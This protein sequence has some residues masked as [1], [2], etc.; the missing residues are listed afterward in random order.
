M[1]MPRKMS[2]QVRP[3]VVG[4]KR[5]EEALRDHTFAIRR[6]EGTLS[7]KGVEYSYLTLELEDETAA[8]ELVV[9]RCGLPQGQRVEFVIQGMSPADGWV[10]DR[11]VIVLTEAGQLVTASFG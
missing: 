10:P 2:V 5:V 6:D 4:A 7:K 9:S 11:L 3:G 8:T 1:V